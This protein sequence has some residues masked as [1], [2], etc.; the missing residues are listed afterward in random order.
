MGCTP[1]LRARAFT[2][3]E[4]MLSIAILLI[5]IAMLLP[6]LGRVRFEAQCTTCA[7][8]LRSVALACEHY[9]SDNDG[10]LPRQDLANATGHNIWDVDQ[11]FVDLMTNTYSVPLHNLYCP[12][13]GVDVMDELYASA[14][15]WGGNFRV[16]G[17]MLWIPRKNGPDMDP[18]LV[19]G[20]A[21]YTYPMPLNT[22]SFAGPQRLQDA[23]AATNPILTDIVGSAANMTPPSTAQAGTPDN[24]YGITQYSNHQ[25]RSLLIR[26]N[27]AYADGHVEVVPA[28]SLRPRYQFDGNGSMN[29]WN[30]R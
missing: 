8:N 20:A 28:S 18:P 29:S 1:S 16:I 26:S 14:T 22:T 30:W 23:T 2:L 17:Y 9:A 5:L 13:L 6:A 12:L 25:W 24:P 21:P 3:F 7:A 27:Q 19:A 11:K 4:L 10:Y 15:Q